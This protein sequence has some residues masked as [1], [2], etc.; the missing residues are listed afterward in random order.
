MIKDYKDNKK[1]FIEDIMHN[2]KTK[3]YIHPSFLKNDLD[4]IASCIKASLGNYV[5]LKE[6]N[7]DK[8]ISLTASINKYLRYLNTSK[9]E[10]DKYKNYTRLAYTVPYAKRYTTLETVYSKDISYYESF[11]YFCE[12]LYDNLLSNY[13]KN[14]DYKSMYNESKVKFFIL[15][16]LDKNLIE[17]DFNYIEDEYTFKPKWFDNYSKL[18]KEIYI[19]CRKV[20]Q[21][22]L[23]D[24]ET[25]IRTILSDLYDTINFDLDDKQ[26]IKFACNKIRW[27]FFRMRTEL[28][29][30]KIY[31]NLK[32]RRCRQENGKANITDAYHHVLYNWFNI[33]ARYEYSIWTKDYTNEI[34]ID[35]FI[36]DIDYINDKNKKFI[37]DVFKIIDKKQFT[38]RK[39]RNGKWDINKTE[40][41]KKLK[42]SHDA[43]EKRVKRI[44][45]SAI[46]NGEI[47]P[48]ISHEEII[49]KPK[50]Y[51]KKGLKRLYANEQNKNMA[52]YMNRKMENEVERN[53]RMMNYP[54]ITAPR[55]KK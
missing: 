15:C 8:Q 20:T 14:K 44:K 4:Y 45:L 23:D 18:Y 17:T 37:L 22:N 41:A 26:I 5:V 39:N 24:Y 49:I 54:M 9:E 43:F 46:K 36:D 3:N 38:Y 35:K 16:M 19:H 21:S 12:D 42:L 53:I 25:T 34:K 55:V 47:V 32:L 50:C 52:Y 2:V 13:A 30:Y 31:R 40:I 1:E 6:K 29:K 28:P 10:S 51:D 48:D 33:N 11:L 27:M 7:Y